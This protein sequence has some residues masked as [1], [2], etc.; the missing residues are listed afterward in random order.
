MSAEETI[1]FM[2][3]MSTT[4]TGIIANVARDRVN[5]Y[6]SILRDLVPNNKK[7]NN[8]QNNNQQQNNQNNDNPM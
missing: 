3:K 7:K 8:N 5:D 6:L 2:L 4:L 1:T